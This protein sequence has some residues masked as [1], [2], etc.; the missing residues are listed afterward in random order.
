MRG[1]GWHFRAEH[2]SRRAMT[3]M[4]SI[5]W[6]EGFRIAEDID[7]A[8]APVVGKPAPS[9]FETRLAEA[10]RVERERRARLPE[11]NRAAAQ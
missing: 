9:E 8:A 3:D 11:L 1:G 2:C 7:A 10:Q 6:L 5:G 4:A